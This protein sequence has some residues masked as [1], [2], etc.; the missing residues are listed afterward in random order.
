MTLKSIWRHWFRRAAE[1]RDAADELEAHVE[2]L[3]EERLRSGQDEASARRAARIEVG[4]VE[5]VRESIRDVRP[6]RRFEQLLQDL[7]YAA[8]GLARNPTFT[9]AAVLT[10][11]LGIGAN[12][13]IFSVLD[14]VLLRPLPY[15]EPDRL[16]TVWNRWTET[17]RAALSSLE[18][19]DYRE[20]LRSFE[21]FGVLA[22]NAMTLTGAG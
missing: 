15:S 22:G 17:P 14:A 6:G 12:S 21:Q 4:G 8:R 2:L 18:Y 5:Q 9:A 1:E 16:V 10:L 19:F 13:A 20:Q 3:V 11:A 7:R